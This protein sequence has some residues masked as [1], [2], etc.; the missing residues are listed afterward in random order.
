MWSNHVDYVV[1]LSW[2]IKQSDSRA[3]NRLT[4]V[5]C[6]IV[7]SDGTSKKVKVSRALNCLP[8]GFGDII[9]AAGR[10]RNHKGIKCGL[11]L[12]TQT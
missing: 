9:S 2:C 4:S 1:L 11:R 7:I 3:I 5:C 12:Y 8:I 6:S 10:R